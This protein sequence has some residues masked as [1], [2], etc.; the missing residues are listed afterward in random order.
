M[1]STTS[2]QSCSARPYIQDSVLLEAWG[3]LCNDIWCSPIGHGRP[4]SLTQDGRGVLISRQVSHTCTGQ[5]HIMRN[6]SRVKGLLKHRLGITT[7]SRRGVS[8]GNSLPHNISLAIASSI[9][10]QGAR[11]ISSSHSTRVSHDSGDLR[12]RDY[13]VEAH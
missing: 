11:E 6:M 13:E 3:A 5:V 10:Q 2:E 8:H 7:F 4:E 1:Y 12:P 9:A